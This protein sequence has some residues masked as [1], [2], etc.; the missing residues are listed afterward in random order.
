[1]VRFAAVGDIGVPGEA[2]EVILRNVADEL[3][4][5]DVA[6]C[7][8]ELPISDRGEL[9]PQVVTCEKSHPRTAAILKRDGVDVVSWASNH[10]LDFG[11]SAFLDTIGALEQEGLVPL[12]VGTDLA[13]ARQVRLVER[14]GVRIA[15]LGFCSVLPA[16]YWATEHRAGVVPVRA[17]TTWEPFEPAQPGTPGTIRTVAHPVDLANL[18][19]DVTR[20]REMAD[21]VIVSQHWGV[22]FTRA[23]IADYQ[24]EVAHAAI[25]AGADLIIGHH[26]HI[27]KGVEMYRG[28]AIFYSVGNFALHL[29]LDPEHAAS[30]HFQYVLGLH[31]GWVPDTASMFPFPQES[32][33]TVI[34]TCEL[35]ADGVKEVAFKPCYIGTDA[36]PVLDAAPE[37]LAPEDPRFGR[38]VQYLRDIAAEAG[39]RSELTIVGDRVV[40]G[41]AAG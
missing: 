6:F 39:V 14:D 12:G 10:S 29:S 37:I 22:H 4:S 31:P 13:S 18:V 23:V 17:T 16:A 33:Q 32:R 41:P 7:Q 38:V 36:S 30:T 1:M 25:D 19:E 24:R 35:D 26:A 9:V 21:V 3:R 34:V 28:K 2:M 40:V 8:L 20:A 15:F 5:A 11:T 27:L